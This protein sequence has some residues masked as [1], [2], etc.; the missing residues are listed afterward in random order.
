MRP[1]V[2]RPP[3]EPS[4]A[5]QAVI[6]VVRRGKL[7]VFLRLHRHEL[8]DEEFQAELAGAY[9]DSP[10]GQPPV[11]PAQ[12]ALAMLLQAYTRVSD[13]EVIEAAATDR[14]W[15]LVLDC[16]GA[17]EPP[18]AKGTLVGFRKR[19]IEKN[20]DRVLVER[21]V[22]LAAATQGFGARASNSADQHGQHHQ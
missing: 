4:P 9:A 5:E 8:F 2:W 3:V 22:R 14:R 20:L 1:V 13:D 7:F 21:S 16:L 6:K 18:F 11:P 10:K 19:L 17:E 15:Q 12:L